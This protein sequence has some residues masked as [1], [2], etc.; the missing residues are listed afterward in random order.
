MPT[1]AELP[2]DT[3]ASADAMAEAIFG[4]GIDIIS[5]SY[6]G[7]D[8]ASGIYSNGDS[9]APAI[10][11]SD[12]GVIL[13]TGKAEDIT[14]SSGDVNSANNRSTNHGEDGDADL[15]GIAGV[16]TYDAAIFE[17]EFVPD[18]STLTMQF[19][20]SSEEYLEYVNA[21]FND[22][23]GVWVNG[24]QAELVIGD[25]DISIDN[26]N[27]ESNENLYID[28]PRNEDNFNTE[29]DGFTMTLTLKAPVNPGE[30]NTI[31]IGI[32]DGGDGIYDSNLL[33][34]GDS[35]Q[36]ALVAGDDVVQ[37]NGD[38]IEDVDVLANDSSSAGGS[39]TI[40]HINGQEV[41]AGDTVTL[42]T[43]EVITLN[44]DGTFDIFND[45]D[46]EEVNTFSY[47][48]ADE[49]GN[50]DI[51]F[52]KVKTVPCFVAGTLIRTPDGLAPVE[53]LTPG[54][55]VET[56]DHGPQPLRWSGRSRRKAQGRHAPVVFEAGALGQHDRIAMSPNHRVLITS[57]RAELLFGQAEVL[58]KAAHLVNDSSIRVQADGAD[59][60]YVHLLFDQHEIVCGNGLESESYH[61]GRETIDSFDA[62]TRSEILDLLDGPESVL[63]AGPAARPSLRAHEI[64][65]LLNS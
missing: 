44:A 41:S 21:G 43:G 48:V 28:N 13:S 27:D 4:N 61:P 25:G 64:K 50:T 49:D 18:G 31:K 20:F 42:P 22:A 63:D 65:V 35:V 19:V 2:I 8:S 56:R 32:A 39:L 46:E 6:T 29:M 45:T 57:E 14:N 54:M 37:I 17:A 60:T 23:V 3:S 15:Q 9:T 59:V 11:P 16:N 52:V 40:T 36:T 47:T 53:D 62:A 12:T 30:V 55:L 51:G 38:T 7:D 34:A 33:I 10:T 24:V 5:A 26:I 58:V 1:A